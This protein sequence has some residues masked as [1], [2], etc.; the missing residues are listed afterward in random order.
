MISEAL[1]IKRATADQRSQAMIARGIY[2]PML[3]D[4][5][6]VRYFEKSMMFE[7][8]SGLFTRLS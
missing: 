3:G 4:P 6:E 7:R 5:S 8:R 1:T 2:K